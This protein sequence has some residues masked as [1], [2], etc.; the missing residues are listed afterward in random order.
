MQFIFSRRV[1]KLQVEDLTLTRLSGAGLIVTG[2]AVIAV[3]VLA[4]AGGVR[5]G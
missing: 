1:P 5:L 2:L 3:I 4:A